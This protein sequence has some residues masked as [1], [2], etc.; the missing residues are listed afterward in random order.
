MLSSY[1]LNLLLIHFLIETQR[2]NLIINA[3]DRDVNKDPHFIYKRKVRKE[4]QEFAVFFSFKT[5]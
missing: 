5:N 4:D 1:G 3:R 2:A